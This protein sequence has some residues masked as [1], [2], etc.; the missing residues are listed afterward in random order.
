MHSNCMLLF[1]HIVCR[2]TQSINM[3]RANTCDPTRKLNIRHLKHI[4]HFGLAFLTSM[5]KT[6]LNI[7]IIPQIWLAKIDTQTK[8]DKGTSYRPISLLPIIEKLLEKSLLPY[9]TENTPIHYGY[10]TQRS[11]VTTIHTLNNTV[12]RGF[13]QMAPPA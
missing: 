7:N 1:D 9:I 12:A 5:L 8:Q 6:V 11:T 10:K 13:N 3:R 2:I 4:G